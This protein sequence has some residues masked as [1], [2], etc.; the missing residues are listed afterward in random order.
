MVLKLKSLCE[1][2]A[3][4]DR[5]LHQVKEKKKLQSRKTCTRQK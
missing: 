1:I 3:V 2:I 5:Y 4:L